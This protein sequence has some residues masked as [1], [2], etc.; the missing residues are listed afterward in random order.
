MPKKDKRVK[1]NHAGQNSTRELIL[2]EKDQ[3]YGNV[4]KS[5][6]N[7]WFDVEC[8]DGILR[9]CQVRGSMRNRK[10]VNIGDVVI[11]SLRDF[12]DKKA[13]IIHV[14]NGDEVR[15]LKKMGEFLLDVKEKNSD[16]D[17]EDE[18][19]FDFESI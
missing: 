9:K 18:P 3:T 13:D 2:A 10:F 15:T 19:G 17:N 6:G 14:Y 16:I 1:N 4:T 5:L 11:V 12:Q 8:Q 7:R